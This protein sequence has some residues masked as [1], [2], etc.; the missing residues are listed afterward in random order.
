M[1]F[2]LYFLLFY[3]YCISRLLFHYFFFFVSFSLILI[4]LNLTTSTF[5]FNTPSNSRN[6]VIN[7]Y[8]VFQE[9]I[10]ILYKDNPF[11]RKTRERERKEKKVICIKCTLTVSICLQ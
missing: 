10:I 2:P 3:Y 1:S 4:T 8:Y 9:K 6:N 5:I 7:L 11:S